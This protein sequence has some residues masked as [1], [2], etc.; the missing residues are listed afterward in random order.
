MHAFAANINSY[1][2]LEIICRLKLE[3]G[4]RSLKP[5][6][7]RMRNNVAGKTCSRVAWDCLCCGIN[8]GTNAHCIPRRTHGII[9]HGKA[10]FFYATQVTLSAQWNHSTKKCYLQCAMPFLS[11][12][13][14][15]FGVHFP[16]VCL[17]FLCLF[18]LLKDYL[19]EYEPSFRYR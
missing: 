17:H 1:K 8:D 18:L 19:L 11:H 3:Y 4:W 7:E 14:F 6:N 15:W 5:Y 2:K 12:S 9:K 16:S 10:F 13:E